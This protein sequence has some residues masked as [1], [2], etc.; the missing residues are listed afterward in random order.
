VPPT[1]QFRL[2]VEES[3]AALHLRV[4][5]EFDLA[6]VGRVE[7]ALDRV[8]QAPTPKRVVLD[9]RRLTFL[10][11][12]GLRTILGANERAR[13]AAC[14]LRVIRPRGLANRVF[15]LTRAGEQ[16]S[17]VDEPEVMA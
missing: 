4:M 15:T 9:L 11:A 8:F 12:A 6:V 13:A 5:G 14:E 16:L 2:A 17:M 1:G 10:D 7:S 3:G